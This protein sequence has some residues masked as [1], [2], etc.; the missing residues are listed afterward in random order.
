MFRTVFD[1]VA[2]ACR[3]A[4]LQDRGLVPTISRMMITPMLTSGSGAGLGPWVGGEHTG[5]PG[6]DEPASR[7]AHAGSA[8]PWDRAARQALAPA[9]TRPAR[10]LSKQP[11]Q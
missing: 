3:A 1:A 2:T 10:T 11:L 6:I 4:S 9:L 5:E 8:D 7:P